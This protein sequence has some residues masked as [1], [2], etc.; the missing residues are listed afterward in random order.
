VVQM[1]V[2][3]HGEMIYLSLELAKTAQLKR[4]ER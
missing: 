2:Y 1:R 4:R 3:T